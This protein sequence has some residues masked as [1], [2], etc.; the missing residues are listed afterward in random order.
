[1]IQYRK[2]KDI[3]DAPANILDKQIWHCGTD[4]ENTGEAYRTRLCRLVVLCRATTLQP[5]GTQTHRRG[6]HTNRVTRDLFAGVLLTG[7]L[8]AGDLLR[9][10]LFAGVL[11]T[12]D[13]LAGVLL[14]GDLLVVDQSR[15]RARV[16]LV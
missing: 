16:T 11:R 4:S 15:P 9:G 2:C 8:L 5:K 12:G 10:D 6:T 1:M 7:D 3:P 13:V 14:M